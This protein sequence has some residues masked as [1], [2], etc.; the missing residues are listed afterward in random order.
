MFKK[1]RKY[2]AGIMAAAMMVTLL[3]AQTTFASQQDT[4]TQGEPKT[5]YSEGVTLSYNPNAETV[6]VAVYVTDGSKQL[7]DNSDMKSL[8][9]LQYVNSICYAPVGVIQLPKSFFADNSQRY[10]KNESI[11]NYIVKEIETNGINTDTIKIV[12]NLDNRENTVKAHLD[13][14]QVE[15]NQGPSSLRTALI[16]P[17]GQDSY[18]DSDIQYHLD[19][20]FATNTIT[21]KGVYEDQLNSGTIDENQLPVLAE[22]AF[23]TGTKTIAPAD[24]KDWYM[25]YDSEH[26]KIAD[27]NYYKTSACNASE[28]YEFGNPLKENTT[29]YVKLVS[30]TAEEQEKGYT[31]T[32]DLNGGSTSSALP[33]KEESYI[34]RNLKAGDRTPAIENPTREGYFFLG[35]KKNSSDEIGN[36]EQYVFGSVTYTAQWEQINISIRPENTSVLYDGKKHFIKLSVTGNGVTDNKNG[37]ITVNG[38]EYNIVPSGGTNAGT[39]TYN[40]VEIYDQSGKNVTNRF[41]VTLLSTEKP[42]QLDIMKR[43]VFLTSASQEKEYDGTELSNTTVTVGGDGFAEGEG[44]TYIF[45]DTARI[46]NPGSVTNEFGYTLKEGTNPNNYIIKTKFGTLT[47]TGKYTLTINYIDQDGNSLAEPYVTQLKEGASFGPIASPSIEGYTPAYSSISSGE[48]GMPKQDVVIN[49]VYTKNPENQGTTPGGTTPE[50]TTPGGTTPGGT[51]PGGTT[52]GETTPG[53]T[54]PGGTT[55]DGTTA[56]GTTPARMT[57]NG[58]APAITVNADNANAQNQQIN[59]E[60]PPAGALSFDENGNPQIVE[61]EDEGTAL[62]AK[63]ALSWALVNL[64]AMVLTVVLCLLLL[65]TYFT[66]KKD[67]EQGNEE[68]NNRVESKAETDEE[69]EKE[70]K[71]HGMIRLLSL[72]PAV[73]SVIVFFLTENMKNPMI[74]VDKWTIWMILILAVEVVLAV[75]SKKKNEDKDEEDKNV[76]VAEA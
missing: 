2:F 43:E 20:R 64:I 47:V 56:G 63:G 41:N 46:T 36:I 3:P 16:G 67:E 6:K 76:S 40:K 23:L 61:I 38:K 8:L 62:G 32:Y 54:T 72:I 69:K 66:K 42:A 59:D 21:F 19:L 68:E 1:F 34:Y 9:G 26:Y 15:Y 13:K 4:G 30:T 50:G 45:K 39:Y 5:N 58:A 25:K 48:G 75:L 17:T 73:G 44:A 14:V 65:V 70:L 7:K 11:W 22:R 49:V 60:E 74:M 55:P 18:T 35:W 53:G 31:V 33:G 71:R 24:S 29:V 37:S 12:N 28:K 51:T 27:D 52:P 57:Q 10:L